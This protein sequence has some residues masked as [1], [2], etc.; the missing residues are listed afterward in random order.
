MVSCSS[1]GRIFH[2]LCLGSNGMVYAAHAREMVRARLRGDPH[3][4]DEVF[5]FQRLLRRK[6]FPGRR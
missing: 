1:A 5:G 2:A 3:P 4:L 6:I